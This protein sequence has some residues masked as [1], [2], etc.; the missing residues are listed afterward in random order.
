MRPHQ[1]P[2]PPTRSARTPKKRARAFNTRSRMGWFCGATARVCPETVRRSNGRE[3]TP[4]P[5]PC[6]RLVGEPHRQQ[7]H[8][9]PPVA[10]IAL[11]VLGGPVGLVVEVAWVDLRAPG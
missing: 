2:N 9:G 6:R 1:T 11:G 5:K 7:V 3:P 8:L 10:V 4:K